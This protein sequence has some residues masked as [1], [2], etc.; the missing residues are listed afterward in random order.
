MS[1][2][3]HPRRGFT[4]VELMGATAIMALL[5]TSSFVLVRTAHNAWT[6]HRDDCERR[7]E[8]IATLQHLT[9]K[10]RQATA[11]TAISTAADTSGAITLSMP[12]G[13][14]AIW[15]HNAGTN[16]VLYGTVTPTN[17]LANNI[18]EMTL[19]GVKADGTNTT[20]TPD[21]IHAIRC[22]VRYTLSR[23]TGIVTETVS[24]AAW[25]RSW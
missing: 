12:G 21:L 8:A 5:T 14:T 23:P 3:S 18:T 10:V 13:T 20:T 17:L 25:L 19:V 24:S 4:L 9:R 1:P 11:V 7:R 16:Q 22:T 15:D 6:R 2:T